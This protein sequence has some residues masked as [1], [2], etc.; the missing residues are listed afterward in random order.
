MVKW[1]VDLRRLRGKGM[2]RGW[3]MMKEEGG[4]NRKWSGRGMNLKEGAVCDI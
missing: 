3:L 1:S 2:R 4:M